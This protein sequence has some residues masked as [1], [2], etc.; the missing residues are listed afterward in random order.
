MTDVTKSKVEMLF[1]AMMEA[2]FAFLD[3]AYAYYGGCSNPE[4][5]EHKGKSA[6][7]LHDEMDIAFYAF[8]DANLAH[9][10]AEEQEPVRVG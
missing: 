9:S 8:A 3:T 10:D 2:Q 4:C 6:S 5:P 7:D 1:D